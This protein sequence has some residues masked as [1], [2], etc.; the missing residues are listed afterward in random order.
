[1]KSINISYAMYAKCDGALFKDRYRSTRL[2]YT[3]ELLEITAMLRDNAGESRWN[4]Y[5]GSTSE[6]EDVFNL[7]DQAP[8]GKDV[9]QGK[10][11]SPSYDMHL[12]ADEA[13]SKAD[14]SEHHEPLCPKDQNCIECAE[15]AK[16]KL[17]S[18]CERR[19]IS[20]EEMLQDKPLRN[21]LIWRIRQNSTLSLKAL[22]TLFGG[23]S[24]S[25]I[26]KLLNKMS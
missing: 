20:F 14:H 7:L 19:Q 24:E 11:L 8:M 5:C 22:G 10:E 15:D 2:E 17:L 3:D 23:L 25:T 4:S 26:C 6:S 16:K 18:E 13:A 1:M 21:Q 9:S 12:N